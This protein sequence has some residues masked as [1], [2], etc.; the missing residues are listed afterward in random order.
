MPTVAGAVPEVNQWEDRAWQAQKN[1]AQSRVIASLTRGTSMRYVQHKSGQGE[2]WEVIESA[3]PEGITDN[4][5][6]R[7]GTEWLVRAKDH[8]K[9]WHILPQSEYQ[10]CEPPEVW[11]DVTHECEVRSGFNA[12][13]GRLSF[14]HLNR[15]VGSQAGY[16]LREVEIFNHSYHWAFI[17]EQKQ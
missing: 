3:R 11:K 2:K 4:W 7:R 13:G 16:R 10:L 14:A 17:V 9:A 6:V 5:C 8:P 12:D 1:F 15:M